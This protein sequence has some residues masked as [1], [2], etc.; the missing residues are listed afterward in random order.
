[1]AL[2]NVILT[3]EALKEI[4]SVDRRADRTRIVERIHKLATDPR[5]PGSKKLK[6]PLERY[7][8]RQ[9]DYR[10][11]YE[12]RDEVLIVTIVHV[13]NRKDVYRRGRA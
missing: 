2:Y 10:I 9:G 4:E 1:V 3:K 11:L 5:P 6:G 12:I 8:L 13:G 7:R